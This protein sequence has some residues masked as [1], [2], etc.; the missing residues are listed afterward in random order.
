MLYMTIQ[1]PKATWSLMNKNEYAY[2][3]VLLC[4]CTVW[5]GYRNGR[6]YPAAIFIADVIG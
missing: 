5:W 6:Y 1:V 4:D 2:Y 3:L